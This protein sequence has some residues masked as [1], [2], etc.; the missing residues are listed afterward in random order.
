MTKYIGAVLVLFMVYGCAMLQGAPSV[1][2]NLEERSLLCEAAARLGVR[3]EDVGNGLIIANAGAI[4]T[5]QYTRDQ[6]IEILTHLR[7][8][9]QNPVSYVLFI[10]EVN[11]MLRMYPGMLTVAESYMDLI[12]SALP[13]YSTDRVLL[14][15]WLN[16][17]IEALS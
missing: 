5:G 13:I 4:A 8:F 1:C 10:K 16:D 11:K 9:A 14:V 17:Q 7:N 6:A 3:L 12:A 2:D 15:D